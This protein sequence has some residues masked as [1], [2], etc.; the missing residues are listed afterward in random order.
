MRRA[1]GR[2]PR[3]RAAR[4]CGAVCSNGSNRARRGAVC[5]NGSN[6]ARRGPAARPRALLCWR[7]AGRAGRGVVG[8]LAPHAPREST[9]AARQRQRPRPVGGAAG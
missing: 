7:R 2:Q 4:P 3:A 1:Q 6:R 8:R 5:S 9:P